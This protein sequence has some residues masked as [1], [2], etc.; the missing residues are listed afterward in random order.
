MP[1]IVE[2]AASCSARPKEA[3]PEGEGEPGA[4]EQTSSRQHHRSTA[5][6]P[7]AAPAR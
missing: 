6:P 4:T 2:A 1:G 5:A 7:R 3:R